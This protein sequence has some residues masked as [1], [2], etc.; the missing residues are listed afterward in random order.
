MDGIF[1]IDH[2]ASGVKE[3]LIG[4]FSLR[5][6]LTQNDWQIEKAQAEG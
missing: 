6:R 1:R 4:Y 5:N 3:V 2:H